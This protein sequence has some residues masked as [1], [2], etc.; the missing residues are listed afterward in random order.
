MKT[1]L[2]ENWFKLIIIIFIFLTLYFFAVQPSIY[3]KYCAKKAYS[4]GFGSIGIDKD[5]TYKICLRKY[6]L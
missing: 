6:G 3:K 2:K 5:E 4:G 1:W